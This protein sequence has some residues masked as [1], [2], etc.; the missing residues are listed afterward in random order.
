MTDVPTSSLETDGHVTRSLPPLTQQLDLDGHTVSF[1]L[2]MSAASRAAVLCGVPR[3]AMLDLVGGPPFRIVPIGPRVAG[4]YIAHTA[5]TDSP[6]GP[7][8]E[9]SLQVPVYLGTGSP[10]PGLAPVLHGLLDR[11]DLVGEFGYLPVMSLVDTA[12]AVGFRRD[13][14]SIPVHHVQLRSLSSGSASVAQVEHGGDPVLRLSVDAGG[15]TPAPRRRTSMGTYGWRDG[16]PWQDLGRVT[17]GGSVR[18]YRFGAGHVAI[19]GSGPLLDLA[20]RLGAT[21]SDGFV[22]RAL[23][24][25][26]SGEGTIR[27]AGPRPVED[28]DAIAVSAYTGG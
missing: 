21:T 1:P 25:D 2:A 17:A 24:S 11:T 5:W 6:V 8:Q 14:W 4:L 20:Y 13:L 12:A 3:R 27:W 22:R 7:F 18:R 26:L 15:H 23:I 19:F 10:V 9:V 28:V 16:V